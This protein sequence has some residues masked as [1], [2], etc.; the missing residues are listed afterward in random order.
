[1]SRPKSSLRD[2]GLSS[3]VLRIGI[4]IGGTFTDF[5]IYDPHTGALE[6]FK[7]FSTPQDPSEAVLAG[8]ARLAL[9]TDLRM[10]PASE[11]TTR[12]S[13]TTTSSPSAH[14]FA[15]NRYQLIH[16]STVATNALLE[17]KGASTALVATAGFRDVLQ[18]GRQNRPDLYDLTSTPTP[19]LIPAALRFEVSERVAPDGQVLTPLAAESLPTLIDSL[20]AAAVESVAVCLLFSFTHPQHE[21]MLAD[22]LRQAGFFVSVSSEVLPEYREYERASTTAV[23]AYVTPV[24][25]RYLGR[26]EQA[27]LPAAG[28]DVEISPSPSV[29]LRVMQSNGGAISLDEARR[30]GVR[31]ILSGPAGGVIGARRVAQL[32][33]LVETP[34]TQAVQPD[35]AS[36]PLEDSP[37]RA[38]VRVITFDMGGT[39]TDV[40]LIDAADQAN[41]L[42]LST[43]AVVGGYPIGIPVLDIHTIGAGGGSL[44]RVDPGGALRVGPESAGADPGPLCYGRAADQPPSSLFPTVT[45]ANLVLGRLQAE[46][47]MGGQ[48][49]LQ[50]APA[51]AALARLGQALSLS[52]VQTALGVIEIVN[53][54]M[55][56]ALRVISVERG[57]DPHHFNLLSFG[58]AGGLHAADLARRLGIPRVIIPPLAATLSAFGMLAADVVKDYT[59]TV[60]LPGETPRAVLEQALAPMIARARREVL[61]EGIVSPHLSVD[62]RLDMRYRGQSYELSVPFGKKRRFST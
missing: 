8:M 19:P 11:A 25:A 43:E 54:H 3:H 46:Y 10:Q 15:A 55:E 56:R 29:L 9:W 31:C 18:I 37:H 50:M 47:F 7:L 38:P 60:M 49:P 1:M 36:G 12:S 13:E 52:P 22:R 48:I 62:A 26:L 44:A 32:A 61:A 28:S 35:R 27:L 16:G 53:A 14:R 51:E 41:A 6:T 30:F 45:D 23:N 57:Y 39:S 42:S 40:S 59:H 34:G 21:E 2:P 33:A 58:G 20:Q 17:R 4:D 24:L 5:V